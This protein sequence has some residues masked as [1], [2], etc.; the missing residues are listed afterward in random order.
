MTQ[1][2]VVVDA[3]GQETRVAVAKA[4]ATVLLGRADGP[5]AA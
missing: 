2:I 5:G 1:R 4:G 3:D